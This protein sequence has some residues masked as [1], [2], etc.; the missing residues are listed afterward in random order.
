M[1]MIKPSDMNTSN[2]LS[3]L[4]SLLSERLP[5]EQY[6][7]LTGRLAMI[8]NDDSLR[9]LHI[10]FGLIP[11]RLGRADLI[12]TGVDSEAADAVLPGWKLDDWSIDMT[13]RVL[14]LCTVAYRSNRHFSELFR[15][16]CQT[17]DLSESVALYK[18]IALYPASDEPDTQIGEGLRTHI[19]AIFEAI[20]HNNPY[21]A[22]HFSVLRW[23]HMVLKALF[24][25]SALHPIQGLEAR[26]NPELARILCDY[27]H[28]RWSAQRPV[29]HELWRCVGPF[30]HDDMIDDLQK[31][32]DSPELL[33]HQAAVL[34]LSN[35]PDP[36][37]RQL[38]SPH[39]A[40][41]EAVAKAR[42]TWDS[43]GTKTT[44]DQ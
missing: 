4:D 36:R 7:W 19:R 14:L 42:L 23:N 44:T 39:A 30:A 3:L 17:A 6:S 34:A 8:N 29:T 26:A 12:P 40:E 31:A 22:A 27:A 20:A 28:E 2:V 43:I 15:S 13:A 5:A 24:I 21:P 1:C 25:E 33:N 18:G 37:A 16:M 11:R 10:S 38:L 41:A 35:C 32:L 9:D